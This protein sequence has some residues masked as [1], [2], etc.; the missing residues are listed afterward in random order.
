MD[1]NY[2]KQS[3]DGL[4]AN[5]ATPEQKDKD[6]ENWFLLRGDSKNRL[7]DAALPL[8][9]LSVRIGTLGR[10]DEVKALQNQVVEE[11]KTIELEL[12]SKGYEQ[13]I[14]MAYRY[15]LCAFLDEAVLSTCWGSSSVWAEQSLLSYFHNETWGGEKVFLITERIEEEPVR[16]RS[17]LEFIYYCLVLG[18][19][20]KYRVIEG[21]CREREAVISHLHQM[22]SD[23]DACGDSDLFRSSGHAVKTKYRLGRQIPVW[24]VFFGFTLLW[25]GIY[26]GYSYLLHAKSTDVLNQL[27]H[28]L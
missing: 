3:S 5:N 2:E 16:Y 25:A 14:L 20:G 18:F 13:S 10:C 22:L 17:L 21:G 11:I 12:T 6:L 7:I 26:F 24:S 1:S 8:L 4:F 19:E 9:A 27:S 23:N 15:I 28:I